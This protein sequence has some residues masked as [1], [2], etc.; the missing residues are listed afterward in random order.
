MK[1]ACKQLL[2]GWDAFEDTE[3]EVSVISGGI[4][5]ALYKLTPPSSPSLSPIALR[6]YGIGTD[7]FVDREK[8][9]KTMQLLHLNG[10]GPAIL[11]LFTNG[12]IESFLSMRCLTP[13]EMS[14]PNF[15]KHI[16]TTLYKFHSVDA[17]N[18]P[19]TAVTPFTR[20]YEWLD[21]AE[22]LD[23]SDDPKKLSAF[24]KFDFIEL[25]K[26]V[27]AVEAAAAPLKSP[28]VFAHNDL[29]SGNIMI[30]L[31]NNSC[32][33]S[34]KMDK[35]TFIDFE[36]S[37]WAPRGFD[38]GN[39]FC[40]YAGFECDYDKYPDRHIAG[41]FLRAYLTEEAILLSQRKNSGHG[42]SVSDEAVA[43]AVAEAN[44]YSLAAHQYWG[45][46]ALI[47][48]RWSKI[49]FDYMEYAGMR[50]GEYKRRKNEFLSEAKEAAALLLE[51]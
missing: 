2:H 16:A 7:K 27:E 35:M 43:I 13:D 15:S 21:I 17:E 50:W 9:V 32:E 24:Q 10:F 23:F 38:L 42:T 4:S 48:A 18:R 44:V 25:K 47:Q 46:W 5:N 14:S 28:I 33:S 1:A 22:K 29:L 30:P 39:H 41:T 49:D 40:E 3:I 20:I 51:S 34:N 45:I 36:Y 6:I 19:A 37:G 26:E 8:E 12:R 11:G 31:E